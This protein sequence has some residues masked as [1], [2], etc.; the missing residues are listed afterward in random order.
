MSLYKSANA[1]FLR[2]KYA[3]GETTKLLSASVLYVTVAG[4]RDIFDFTAVVVTAVKIKDHC[5][6]PAFK[7]QWF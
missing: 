3:L 6:V 1:F 5:V 4:E 7:L 2:P